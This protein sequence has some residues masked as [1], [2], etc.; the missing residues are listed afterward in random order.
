[1]I[2]KLALEGGCP[3]EIDPGALVSAGER[4][5]GSFARCKNLLRGDF[6]TQTAEF[7]CVIVSGSGRVVCQEEVLDVAPGKELDEIISPW[8]QLIAQVDCSIHIQQETKN[9]I[10]LHK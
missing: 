7:R 3:N 8:K 5:C 6:E 4:G 1:M 9:F 2:E 10:E